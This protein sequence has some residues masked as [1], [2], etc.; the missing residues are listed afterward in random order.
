MKVTQPSQNPNASWHRL[1]RD[2]KPWVTYLLV[3]HADTHTHFG[4]IQGQFLCLCVYSAAIFTQHNTVLGLTC[5]TTLV[6][7]S[8]HFA[9]VFAEKCM[10]PCYLTML[11]ENIKTSTQAHSSCQQQQWQQK[12]K[13]TSAKQF[14]S[15]A[16]SQTCESSSKVMKQ[17]L[18]QFLPVRKPDCLISPRQ[19]LQI[20]NSFELP[21]D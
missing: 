3:P 18:M 20:W 4:Q 14:T 16:M 13:W 5:V 19:F 1:D 9:Q 10:T 7:V 11:F 2:Q 21:Y 6:L 15:Q 8:L 12:R 17:I